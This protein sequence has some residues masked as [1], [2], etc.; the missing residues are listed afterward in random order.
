MKFQVKETRNRVVVVT[1]MTVARDNPKSGVVW[2]T[3]DEPPSAQMLKMSRGEVPQPDRAAEMAARVR[4]VAAELERSGQVPDIASLTAD[5]RE[6]LDAFILQQVRN[7]LAAGSAVPGDIE[8][9][10]RSVPDL[11]AAIRD[12]LGTLSNTSSATVPIQSAADALRPEMP[13]VALPAGSGT[14]SAGSVPPSVIR[15]LQDEL[16]QTLRPPEKDPALNVST[17]ALD[18]ASRDLNRRQDISLPQA[19]ER[20]REMEHGELNHDG[21]RYNQKER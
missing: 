13:D 20:G 17:Q 8:L 4:G 21:Q 19:G 15:E 16:Q 7:E 12:V 10:A 1:L 18:A 14:E 6:A 11:S 5:K 9:P 3:G 2:Q